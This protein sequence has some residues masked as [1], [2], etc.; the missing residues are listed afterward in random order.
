MGTKTTGQFI[1]AAILLLTMVLSGCGADKKPE[2]VEAGAGAQETG[3]IAEIKKRGKLIIATG[4][5]YPF[6]YRDQDNKLIGY[7]IDLGNKIGEKLGVPVEWVDMQF[8]ALI[9][10]LQNKQADM[11]IAG[12]YITDERKKVIDMSDSYLATGVSLVKRADDDTVNSMDDIDGKTVGVKAGGTSE[13][14][15]NDL[16]AKGTKLTIKAYKDNPEYL[17]DL[18]LG[19]LDIGFNDYLNQ[20]GYNKQNPDNKLVLVGEPF[21]H[22]DLGIGVQKGDSELLAVANEVIKEFKDSGAAEETFN[23]WLK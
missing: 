23:K 5:Y 1:M 21:V 22:A 8:T 7:D 20:L 19:R 18:S 14:V 3:S 10:T 17:L 4:N 6:E 11:V 13:K 16:V 2:S 15:A 12:M 9:P